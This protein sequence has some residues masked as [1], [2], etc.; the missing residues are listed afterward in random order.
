MLTPPYMS[1][2][3]KKQNFLLIFRHDIH[4]DWEQGRQFIIISLF[5]YLM[6]F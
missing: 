3:F 1:K 6:L 5:S 4:E 2:V